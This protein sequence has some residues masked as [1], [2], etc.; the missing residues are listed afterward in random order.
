MRDKRIVN[1]MGAYRY[2]A[3]RGRPFEERILSPFSFLPSRLLSQTRQSAPCVCIASVCVPP[4][5]RQGRPSL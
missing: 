3:L 1:G 2:D 5:R 4:W